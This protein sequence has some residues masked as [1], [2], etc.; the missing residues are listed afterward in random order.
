MNSEFS[1]I[2]TISRPTPLDVATVAAEVIGRGTGEEI[3]RSG[4]RSGSNEIYSPMGKP[5]TT[6]EHKDTGTCV[7]VSDILTS[8][9]IFLFYGCLRFPH[10]TVDLIAS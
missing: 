8:N 7:N 5:K 1:N 9:C 4:K 3:E 10:G 2:S 6:V